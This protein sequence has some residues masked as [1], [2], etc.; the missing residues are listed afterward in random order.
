ML[1]EEFPARSEASTR[2]GLAPSASVIAQPNWPEATDAGAPLH[3]T[4]SMPERPSVT[5]PATVRD[6]LLR[7]APS[8][9]EAIATLGAVLSMF[10][11]TVTLAEFPAASVAVPVTV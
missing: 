8:G 10:S 11:V 7:N 5:L 1:L 3:W 9:G 2:I 6:A 4:V